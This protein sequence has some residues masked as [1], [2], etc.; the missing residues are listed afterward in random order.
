[1]PSFREIEQFAACSKEIKPEWQRT[2][3]LAKRIRGYVLACTKKAAK[4]KRKFTSKEFKT[5]SRLYRRYTTTTNRLNHMLSQF[6][7]EIPAQLL[8]QYFK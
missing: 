7:L 5:I 4:E 2:V 6:G 8:S 1:M 3:A